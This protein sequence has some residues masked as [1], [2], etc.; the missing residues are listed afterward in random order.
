M[1][2]I[3]DECLLWALLTPIST[4]KSWNLIAS[5]STR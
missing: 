5:Q 3:I 1:K 4:A 2:K